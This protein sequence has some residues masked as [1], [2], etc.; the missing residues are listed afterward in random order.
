MIKI[1]QKNHHAV[2]YFYSYERHSIL[3]MA[4]NLRELT[5]ILKISEVKNITKAANLLH[6]TQ[7][8]LSRL[9]HDVEEDLGVKIFDRSTN[10]LTLTFAGE[11]YIES[12]KKILLEYE[13]LKK[14]IR[15]INQHMTGRLRIGTSR[16]RASFMMPKILPIFCEKY[17]GID[18]EIFTESGKRL[19]EALQDGKLDIVILP[20]TWHGMWKNYNFNSRKIYSEEL[21]LATKAGTI[22]EKYYHK[23]AVG[24]KII[25]TQALKNMKFFLLFKEHAMRTFCE[26]YFKAHKINPEIKMEF[27]SNITCYRMAA[28]GMGVSLVPFLTTLMSDSGGKVEIFYLGNE[29]VT[30]EVK[31]FYRKG[32]YI[33]EPENELIKIA[34][35]SFSRKLL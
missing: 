18:V 21:V 6:I 20:D 19:Q 16:D 2:K 1:L 5:Y 11:K 27:S 32:T 10:P 14:E 29:P 17:P 24:R 13:N 4:L 34:N 31:A 12:A 25:K 35:E 30:W 33:G 8:T 26:Q 3:P 28:A 15:D 9:V 7:P 23:S 22:Q